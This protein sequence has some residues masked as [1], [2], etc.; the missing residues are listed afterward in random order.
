MRDFDAERST[1]LNPDRQFKLAGVVFQFRPSVAADL[2]ADYFDAPTNSDMVAAADRLIESWLEPDCRD[3]WRRAREP[4]QA[5]PVN[6]VD[7]QE[8]ISYM[9][10]V[11]SGRPTEPRGGSSSTRAGRSATSSTVCS[12]AF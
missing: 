9:I 10:A 7:M 6:I 4:E 8:L 11:M 1:R 2:L 3:A 12:T 5:I